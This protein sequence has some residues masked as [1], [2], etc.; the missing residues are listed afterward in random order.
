MRCNKMWRVPCRLVAIIALS[1]ME[2]VSK[3]KYF[4]LLEYTL[5]RR[6]VYN[7]ELIIITV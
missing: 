6:P 2:P 5:M 3:L 7:E 4:M 1:A